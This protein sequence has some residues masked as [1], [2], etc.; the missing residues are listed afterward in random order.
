MR[1]RRGSLGLSLSSPGTDRRVLP[2]NLPGALRSTIEEEP[3]RA[4]PLYAAANR[5]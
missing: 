2:A 3:R 4:F 5:A 1:G